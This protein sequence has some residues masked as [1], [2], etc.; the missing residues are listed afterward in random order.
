MQADTNGESVSFAEQYAPLTKE[1]FRR[2]AEDALREGKDLDE[3]ASRYAELGK[4]DFA[5]AYL[6]AGQLPDGARREVYAL[7]YRKRADFTEERAHTFDRK[8]HRPFPLLLND[9]AND[10]VSARRVLAGLPL[11]PSSGKQLPIL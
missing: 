3:L 6:L 7:A 1:V 8:Y 10:R 4:P 11:N 2:I 5:L 9:A